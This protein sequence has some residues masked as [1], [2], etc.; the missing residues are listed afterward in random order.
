MAWNI[1]W[2]CLFNSLGG[3][4]YAV[5]IYEQNYN[6]SVVQ[7]TG[8]ADPFVTQEDDDDDIFKPIRVQTGYLRVV[9]MDGTLME[10]IIPS[11]NTEKLVRLYS[12]T[13]SSGSFTAGTIM[14]QGFL[15]AQAYT[16]PWDN[17]LKVVEFPVKSLLGALEDV[18]I[19]TS[20]AAS[21]KNFAWYIVQA[22]SSLNE[23]PASVKII[24]N[25]DT[26]VTNMLAVDIDASL[27]FDEDEQNNEGSSLKVQIGHSYKDIM[28]EIAKL[29][30]VCFRMLYGVLYI[31]MY[32]ESA[33]EPQVTD[34][35][36]PNM[37]SLAGGTL[38]TAS[39]TAINDVDLL[40]ETE[41]EGTDNVAEFV[42]G[43]KEAVVRVNINEQEADI[44]E[45]PQ[46][47]ENTN[48]TY[49]IVRRDAGHEGERVIFKGQVFVQPHSPRV[50][51]IETFNFYEYQCYGDNYTYIGTSNY[52]NCLV[53]SVISRPLYNPFWSTSDHL[54]TGAFPCRWMY[55]KDASSQPQLKSGMFFNQFY[56]KNTGSYTPNYCYKIKSNLSQRFRGGYLRIDMKCFNFM[57]GQLAGDSDL[58]YFGQF[59]GIF[60]SNKTTRLYCILTFGNFEWQGWDVGWAP[61]SGNHTTFEL[62]FDGEN[63]KSN[64]TEDM[65]VDESEGYFI[66]VPSTG[67]NGDITLYITNASKCVQL[68]DHGQVISTYDAHSRIITDLQVEYLPD[69]DPMASRRTTNTYRQKILSSGFSEDADREL[70]VG[71]NNNNIP[72]NTFI[73]DGWTL[74]ETLP[75]YY[76]SGDVRSQRPEKNLLARMVAHFGE[77][78][79]AF[80]GV[81]KQRFNAAATYAMYEVRYSY[82][83]RKFFG[84][85]AKT[86]WRDDIQEVKFIEVT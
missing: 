64:K 36:W 53:N 23:T 46:T 20:N 38:I 8:A 58:L 69:I 9:D 45:M 28:S 6:G 14:W 40:D 67:L 83:G 86:R 17:Q 18:S 56:M 77:V 25:L 19:S 30:G 68:D 33:G 12:G 55:K 57:R 50:N 43:A 61:I 22:F 62:T 78:R 80:T 2:Q 32:D 79:R 65:N 48:V 35:T 39:A 31:C 44:I 29:F 63:I 26:V 37:E 75:Y 72:S 76:G 34:L 54:H 7:L 11:N 49:E 70:I 4:Q 84:I 41:F 81:L 27:F 59:T 60:G 47:E 52:Q 42:Q 82:L 16:Q 1:H 73:L 85:A 74:I 71:T 51:N 66:A 5:N 21:T 13:F 10:S 15:Q 3:N 24:S